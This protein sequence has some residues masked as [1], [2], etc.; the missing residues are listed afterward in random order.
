MEGNEGGLKRKMFE[1]EDGAYSELR[2][3]SSFSKV[4]ENGARA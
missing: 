4:E 2:V 3:I 1:V